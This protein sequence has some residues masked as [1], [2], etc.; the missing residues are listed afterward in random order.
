M[1]WRVQELYCRTFNILRDHWDHPYNNVR[2]RD[3][4]RVYTCLLFTES[5]HISKLQSISWWISLFC[6]YTIYHLLKL[7][8]PTLV[9]RHQIAA[10]L[11]TLTN[12]DVPWAGPEAGNIGQ[13]FPTKKLFIEEVTPMLSLNC[14][15]P[16][17]Q[18]SRSLS[19]ASLNTS[20]SSSED[21]SMET[22][23]DEETK[24]GKRILEMVSLWVCHTIRTSS[25]SFDPILY[26]LLPYMCQFIGTIPSAFIFYC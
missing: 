21:V 11:A 2:Q 14:P 24:R 10:T 26:E 1:N 23:E 7:L 3:G 12:M 4:N 15:N 25:S 18:S 13:G 17:F 16:E 22:V 9:L 20:H 19:P 5:F 6:A 8:F